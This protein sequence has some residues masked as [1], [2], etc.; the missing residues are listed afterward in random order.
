[1]RNGRQQMDSYSVDNKFFCQSVVLSL[2]LL[3]VPLIKLHETLGLTHRTYV[4]DAQV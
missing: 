2:S 4:G 1:M 3:H